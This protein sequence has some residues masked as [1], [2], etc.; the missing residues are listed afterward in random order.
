MEMTPELI[1]AIA[2]NSPLAVVAIVAILI[3]YRVLEQKVKMAQ[4]TASQHK[5]LAERYKDLCD[6]SQTWG[7]QWILALSQNTQAFNAN[8]KVMSDTRDLIAEMKNL[9]AKDKRSVS[10]KAE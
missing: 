7:Q 6:S 10:R 4:D 1:R 8:M 5:E 3:L 2:E 9:L